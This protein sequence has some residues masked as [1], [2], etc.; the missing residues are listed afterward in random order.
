MGILLSWVNHTDAAATVLFSDNEASGL[1]IA[2][3]QT[4]QIADVFRSGSWG[5]ATPCTIAIDFGSDKTF[6]MIAL[7]APRDGVLPAPG[8][9]VTRLAIGVSTQAA[10]N[11]ANDALFVN[12]HDI[13]DRMADYGL[14]VY[15]AAS[16]V[17]GRYVNLVFVNNGTASYLQLGRVWI[18]ETLITTRNA[19]LGASLGASDPGV[20]VRANPSGVRDT[21]E[22]TAY[23]QMALIVNTLTLAEAAIIRSIQVSRG[24]TRQVFCAEIDTQAETT[25]FFGNFTRAPTLTRVAPLLYKADFTIEEDL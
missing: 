24:S 17:T 15:Q 2:R 14:Y 16:P 23:R 11:G 13:G 8:A 6:E 19:S 1:P 5:S 22:G 4:P 12:Y 3:I 9:S 20:N 7:Q 10:G 21:Q 25:G 18:G